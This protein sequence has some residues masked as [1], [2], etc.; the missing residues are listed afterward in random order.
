MNVEINALKVNETR[1]IIGLP[2]GYKW[3]YKFK[4]NANGDVER[5]EVHLIV[6]DYT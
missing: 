1:Y 2:L 6:K 5:Y 4:F 3:I